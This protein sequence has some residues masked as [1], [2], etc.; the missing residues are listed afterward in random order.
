M[1]SLTECSASGSHK[2]MIKVL[3]GA[4]V[5][6]VVGRGKVL[7]FHA[8]VV[9]RIQFLLA[10]WTRSPSFAPEKGMAIYFIILALKL[11]WTEEPGR[12]HS[13]GSRRAGHDLATEHVGLRPPSGPRELPAIELSLFLAIWASPA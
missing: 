6:S 5:S 2:A 13:M 1:N 12:I 10:D 9:S 8:Q 4:V 11:L 3:A 7:C